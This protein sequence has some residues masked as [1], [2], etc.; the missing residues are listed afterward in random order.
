MLTAAVALTITVLVNGERIDQAQLD[1]Q[2]VAATATRMG[3]LAEEIEKSLLLIERAVRDE[4]PPAA[5]LYELQRSADRLDQIVGCFNDG[6]ETVAPDNSRVMISPVTDEKAAASLQE[7]NTIWFGIKNQADKPI[8]LQ[9][10]NK[11]L[12]VATMR[13]ASEFVHAQ[14]AR[15]AEHSLA[16]SR[17][18][19]LVLKEE[20]S[21]R[22]TVQGLCNALGMLAWASIPAVWMLN[23]LRRTRDK[24]RAAAEELSRKQTLLELRTQELGNAKLETDR[25]METVQEGLLLMDRESVI[26]NQC[27]AELKTI[28]RVDNPAGLSLLN[29]LQRL[30][31][32]KMYN[33]TKDYF[34]LLFDARRKEKTVLKVNPLDSVEVHF[35]NPNGGFTTRHLGFSFRRIVS[36]ETVE[37]V[38][39]AIKDITAQ[40]ELERSLRE[41]E[42]K[43]DRQLEILLNIIH[44]DASAVADFTELATRE[45]DFINDALKAEDFALAQQGQ[46]EAL[47]ARL[48]RV[49]S[50]VHNIKGNAAV[51]GMD[52][53]AKTCHAFEEQLGVL[54]GKPTLG[55][56]DFLSVVVHQATLKADLG[57]LREL[58]GKLGRLRPAGAAALPTKAARAKTGIPALLDTFAVKAA[59]ELGKD[60]RIDIDEDAAAVLAGAHADMLRDVL[61][62]LTRN[63]LAHSIERPEDRAKLGK[64]RTG[65]IQV[66]RIAEPGEGQVGL[67]FRD[68]G[69]GLDLE[70]IKARAVER[71]LLAAEAAASLPDDQAA[72]L[73]FAPGLSTAETAG[74]HAGRGMGMDII[75]TR[76]VDE[77]GGDLHLHSEPGAFCEFGLYLPAA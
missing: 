58:H 5:A 75:K 25:I 14:A 12:T 62:Q 15:F 8:R 38:F 32:E 47:R 50:S 67:S 26:G 18:M 23:R 21:R 41:A 70:R 43:K 10:Q 22:Q 33:T 36:G 9:S 37:R 3:A 20:A 53:F 73:I 64:P 27:S 42:K 16:F 66:R 51:L 60:V 30:L 69:R 77:A 17:R 68:D 35:S 28:L 49:F 34:A 56:D 76:I 1:H 59:G 45:L 24:A 71:G 54:L 61:I 39:V 6:G 4:Q 57:E 52:S 11:P 55:G 7:M 44:A 63:A 2:R 74:D 29:L 31:T 46:A 13:E 48:K 19:E 72:A 65:L 40:V